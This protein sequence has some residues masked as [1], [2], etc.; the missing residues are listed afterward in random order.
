MAPSTSLNTMKGP[1]V[2]VNLFLGIYKMYRLH[3]NRATT[4]LELSFAKH[5][6]HNNWI[7]CYLNLRETSFSAQPVSS[8]NKSYQYQSR[9]T[10]HIPTLLDYGSSSSSD[11]LL[12]L[13]LNG[14]WPEH[15]QQISRPALQL[16][17]G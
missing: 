15:V 4:L 13:S 5:T 11:I 9:G 12:V 17:S 2:Q 6:I 10:L 3:K 16:V 7:P 8:P 14:T 1:K